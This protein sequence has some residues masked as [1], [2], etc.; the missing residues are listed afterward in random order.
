MILLF[1]LELYCSVF[2]VLISLCVG[3]LN[4][5]VAKVFGDVGLFRVGVSNEIPREKNVD[6]Q[7]AVVSQLSS[8]LDLLEFKDITTLW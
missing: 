5:L 3:L 8:F 7:M 1:L 6:R 4:C 2:T